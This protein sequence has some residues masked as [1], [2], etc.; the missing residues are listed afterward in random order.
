MKERSKILG[1]AARAHALLEDEMIKEIW[2]KLEA[3][4]RQAWL[5]TQS[6]DVAKRERL[7]QAIH[8]LKLVQ[9]HLRTI[10]HDGKVAQS[11]IDAV[12]YLKTA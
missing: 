1:D 3:D 12:T 10:V 11:D 4:Y 9:S 8:I 5:Y 2:A 7:W 6:D